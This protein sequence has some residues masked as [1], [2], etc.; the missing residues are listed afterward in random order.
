MTMRSLGSVLWL[1]GV[2]LSACTSDTTPAIYIDMGYQVRCLNCERAVQD[3]MPREI[4]NVSGENGLTLRCDV[5]KV[6]GT[7]R[8]DFSID[9]PSGDQDNK[10][11]IDVSGNLDSSDPS[12]ACVTVREGDNT[13]SY[14]CPSDDESFTIPCQASFE[15]K[16]NI[17]S[18]MV[19]CDD[20]PNSST[21][22]STRSVVAPNSR[23]DGASF[24]LY[25]CA[26]L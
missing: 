19:I 11:G 9:H 21:N 15:L 14:M 7:R 18:G 24:K 2:L 23:T 20:I 5:H 26:G 16:D 22:E 4:K 17:I 1:G 13:Y 6:N 10:Y 8:V 3:D 25:G 12:D